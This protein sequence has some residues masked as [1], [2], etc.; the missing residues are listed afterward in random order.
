[1]A[2]RAPVFYMQTLHIARQALH[3]VIRLND[4]VQVSGGPDLDEDQER[5]DLE[6]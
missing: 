5:I 3:L 4:T 6:E 2:R 1:M